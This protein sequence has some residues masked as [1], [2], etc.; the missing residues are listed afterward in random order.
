MI[1]E[2]SLLSSFKVLWW[3]DKADDVEEDSVVKKLAFLA[4]CCCSINW[5]Q[6]TLYHRTLVVFQSKSARLICTEP[7][8]FVWLDS[9]LSIL[10]MVTWR[11]L[12]ESLAFGTATGKL[13][14]NSGNSRSALT[15]FVVKDQLEGDTDGTRDTFKYL[16]LHGSL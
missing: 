1:V 12:L 5:R 6:R 3:L 2:S 4:G 7:T 13:S 8:Q 14:P 16:Q 9:I 10:Q 11:V 15:V